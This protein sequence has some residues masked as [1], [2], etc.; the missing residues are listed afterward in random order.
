IAALEQL[1]GVRLDRLLEQPAGQ[2]ALEALDVQPQRRV[3]APL[4]RAHPRMSIS[5]SASGTARR[6]VVQH[7]AQVGVRL[8]VRRKPLHIAAPPA[9]GASV[10]HSSAPYVMVPPPRFVHWAHNTLDALEGTRAMTSERAKA[11]GRV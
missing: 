5:R 1:T 11:Y 6:G 3:R 2:L 7:L 8:P 4:K 10:M 9:P